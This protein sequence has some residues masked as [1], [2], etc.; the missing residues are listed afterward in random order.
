MLD[1]SSILVGF[2]ALCAL[3][4][5]L[6]AHDWRDEYRE[7]S[8]MRNAASHRA[9]HPLRNRWLRRSPRHRH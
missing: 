7:R 9:T 2:A 8:A 1:P 4:L 6:L 3:A 5:V